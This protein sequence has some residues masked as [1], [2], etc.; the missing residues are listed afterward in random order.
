MLTTSRISRSPAFA[1]DWLGEVLLN[2]SFLRAGLQRRSAEELSDHL[3]RDLGLMPR[4]EEP[5]D[6]RD[7]RW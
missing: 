6:L 7:L 1:M 2:W 4:P 5:R 3:R